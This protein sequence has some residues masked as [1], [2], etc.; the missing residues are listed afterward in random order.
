MG[1]YLLTPPGA[2]VRQILHTDDADECRG[3]VEIQQDTDIPLALARRGRDAGADSPTG[4]L[5]LLAEMPMTEY[6][7]ACREGWVDDPVAL[8][9]WLNDP[10]NKYLRV[11]QGRA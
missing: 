5:S 4:E 9:R 10:D 1:Q 2:P 11:R 6:L 3:S 8:R 7:R